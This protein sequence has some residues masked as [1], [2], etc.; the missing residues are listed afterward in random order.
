MHL[1][2]AWVIPPIGNWKLTSSPCPEGYYSTVDLSINT[3]ANY[4]NWIVNF[5]AESDDLISADRIED[6]LGIRQ[7]REDEIR[8]VCFQIL[9]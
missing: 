9:L 6:S 1:G 5:I 3:P 2:C 4:V 7:I 8:I